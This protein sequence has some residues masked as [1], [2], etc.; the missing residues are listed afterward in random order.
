LNG[1]RISPLLIGIFCHFKVCHNIINE[2]RIFLKGCYPIVR[3]S[4]CGAKIMTIGNS[5]Q[6]NIINL[7]VWCW[8]SAL[9]EIAALLLNI[10]RDI[11]KS[12]SNHFKGNII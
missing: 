7:S 4:A 5:Q 11:I 2:F 9:W 1:E 8:N 12:T 6:T 10:R 3:I